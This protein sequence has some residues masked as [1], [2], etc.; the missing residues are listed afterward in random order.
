MPN[1][2]AQRQRTRPVARAARL[3][4]SMRDSVV[5][6]LSLIILILVIGNSGVAV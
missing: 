1:R 6:L 2:I 4:V 3:D 5:V